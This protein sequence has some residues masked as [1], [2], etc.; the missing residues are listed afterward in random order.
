MKTVLLIGNKDYFRE[1]TAEMLKLA[2]YRVLMAENGQQG[3]KLALQQ[4][5]DIVLCAIKRPGMDGYDVLEAFGKTPALASIPFILLSDS[6][7]R[8]DIRAGM[9]HGADDFISKPYWGSELLNVIEVRLRKAELFQK[10]ISPMVDGKGDLANPG[11]QGKE[12]ERLTQGKRVYLYKKKEILYLAG[13]Q[14]SRLFFIRKGKVKIFRSN[15]DGKKL[16]TGICHEGDYFG[17]L[18][19]LEDTEYQETAQ[20]ME[21]TQIAFIP[22]AEFLSLLSQNKQ[23]SKSMLKMLAHNISEKMKLLSEMAYHSLRKRTADSL[24]FLNDLYQPERESRPA[25]QI[26]RQDIADIVGASTESLIRTLS[27]LKNEH[28]IDIVDG[29]IV[30]LDKEKLQKLPK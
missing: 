2:L 23:T 7:A 29:K 13:S 3:I 22:K 8:A 15:Q 24:I 21:D 27:E 5:P 9:E 10:L 17:Y 26:S 19:L 16:I 4:K 1:H 20:A 25:I 6:T 30:I 11:R 14:P 18:P 12:L 28:L